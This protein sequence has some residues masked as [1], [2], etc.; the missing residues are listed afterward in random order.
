M[1]SGELYML[2]VVATFMS[3]IVTLAWVSRTT[4]NVD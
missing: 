4:D 1:S 3:F 2:L